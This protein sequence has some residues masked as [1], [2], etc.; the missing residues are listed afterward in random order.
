MLSEISEEDDIS[1]VS[2]RVGGLSTGKRSAKRVSK[3]AS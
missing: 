1:M 2:E 3:L